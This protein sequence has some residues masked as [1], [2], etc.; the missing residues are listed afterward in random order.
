MVCAELVVSVSWSRKPRL[1][2]NKVALGPNDRPRHSMKAFVDVI[3]SGD[4]NQ[5]L[6]YWVVI[7]EHGLQRLLIISLLTAADDA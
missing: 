2:G 3:A 5:P 6:A 4:A 7:G 1:V